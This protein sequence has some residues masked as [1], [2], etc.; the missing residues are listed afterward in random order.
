MYEPATLGP[1]LGA[2]L[3]AAFCNASGDAR[4]KTTNQPRLR[5]TT[6]SDGDI[7]DET[8]DDGAAVLLAGLAGLSNI[9][10]GPGTTATAVSVTGPWR[11]VQARQRRRGQLHKLA[12]NRLRSWFRANRSH[13]YP[14]EETKNRLAQ[15]TGLSL[16]QLSD[17][18][19]NARRRP[20]DW[21]DA[22]EATLATPAIF[23]SVSASA[24][25]ATTCTS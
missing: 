13:P 21:W 11:C 22:P 8:E 10:V 3:A 1:A 9:A 4:T 12:S 25:A 19:T 23:V 24:S 14:S 2:L 16:R 7:N 5:S 18:F 17:W 15:Q 6:T 20:G